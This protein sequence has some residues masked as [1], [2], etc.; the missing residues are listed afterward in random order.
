M[1]RQRLHHGLTLIEV[2]V[3]ILL[4]STILLASLGASA[5]MKR[6][7]SAARD[8]NIGREL[9][10]QILGEITCRDFRDRKD[11]AFGLELD[12]FAN[13]RTT[14]DDVDD[15]HN[16][17]QSTPTHRD[18][19]LDRRFEGWRYQVSV[20]PVEFDTNG[21]T[22]TGASVDSPLRLIRVDCTSASGETVQA[23]M[24]I[25]ARSLD[26]DASTSYEVWRRVTLDFGD[27]QIDLTTPLRNQP[28]PETP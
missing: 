19:S 16:Y 5:A 24:L 15:Y 22:T 11:A 7:Q 28:I 21:V 26:V 27:R 12:E 8:R 14:F 2:V 25:S 4:V 13:D 20:T 10:R 1:K 17:V 3:S 18:G 9:G 23:T 6:N